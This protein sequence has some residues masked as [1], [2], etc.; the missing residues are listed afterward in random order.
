MTPL[1]E[2]AVK[3]GTDKVSAFRHDYTPFYHYLL[4][5][6]K[7]KKVLEIGIGF[8]AIMCPVDY[9][10]GA[11]LRMWEEYFPEA[12][13][14]ALDIRPDI[15]VN[16][17]RI[18]S[19]VCDQGDA[20]Q[21][22]FMGR[23]LRGYLDLRSDFDLIIDDGSHLAEH[24]VLSAKTLLP[25]L[26]PDGIYI[27]EDVMDAGKVVPELLY[28][29]EIREFNIQEINDDRIVV[30]RGNRKPDCKTA[31]V[32]IATGGGYL[33]YVTP[34]IDSLKRFFP[35]HDV[36]LFTD[37]TAPFD[38]IKIR[39]QHLGWPQATLMRYH[40]M[41]KQKD[42][43]SR[44][45]Q[46]FYMDVDML[47]CDEVGND[48]FSNDL[49][50]VIHP[51]YVT[52]FEKNPQSTAYVE[53]DPSCYYQGCLVGGDA[54]TFM[55]MCETLAKNIDLDNANG[56][57]AIWHDESHLNRYL[58][59]HPPSKTLS[60]AY[61]YPGLKFCQHTERWIENL[62]EGFVPKIRH[63]VKVEDENYHR[64]LSTKPEGEVQ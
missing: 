52:T 47:A 63:L 57:V 5:G 35:P 60:P 9:Q 8:P 25:Y 54:N 64:S 46:I 30:I 36:I 51:S 40:T 37:S 16:E 24:Q 7:V 41:L 39:Q 59:D 19:F 6:K 45:N 21:L 3:Y 62:T 50:A 11:S 12:E 13:I 32:L 4:S 15:M 58:A 49:T 27:I 14:Y 2:L 20:E 17:G 48:L 53:E 55:Q 29:C 28:D 23:S 10:P 34:L 61:C 43:F 33:Q 22:D 18:R 42:L 1:C 44:Y 38:A 31:I 56:I 26:S